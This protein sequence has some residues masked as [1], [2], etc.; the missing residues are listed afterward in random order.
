MKQFIPILLV[1]VL[2]A[3][4]AK[5]SDPTPS[6]NG[7]YGSWSY[8]G[9]TYKATFATWTSSVLGATA[10]KPHTS[11]LQAYFNSSNPPAG[12]YTVVSSG[13]AIGAN[14]VTIAVV[15]EVLPAISYIS[16][17]NNPGTVTVAR[18]GS[19][20]TVTVTNVKVLGFTSKAVADSTVVTGTI[21][22]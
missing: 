7:D 1:V 8:A 11:G 17:G 18:N 20:V 9:D 22:K 19:A 21:K 2:I 12:T 5:S 10:S 6:T 16:P 13:T 3:G 4:C 14:Q 15:D